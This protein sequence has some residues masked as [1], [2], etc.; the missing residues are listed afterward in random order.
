MWLGLGLFS[1]LG[2]W[3]LGVM[4]AAAAA[5]AAAVGCVV[6][7]A[8]VVAGAAAVVVWIAVVACSKLTRGGF[9]TLDRTDFGSG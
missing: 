4:T 8:A 2:G 9:G 7:A 1:L 3:F 5:A 6:A